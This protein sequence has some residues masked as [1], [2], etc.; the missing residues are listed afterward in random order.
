MGGRSERLGTLSFLKSPFIG[1]KPR[2]NSWQARPGN[3]Q[4]NIAPMLRLY[5]PYIIN[6]Q[7]ARPATVYR[8]AL[9]SPTLSVKKLGWGSSVRAAQA[10]MYMI[11]RVLASLE[12]RDEGLGIRVCRDI[13][14]KQRYSCQRVASSVSCHATCCFGL[15][16]E[17][18]LTHSPTPHRPRRPNHPNLFLLRLK[19][20]LVNKTTHFCSQASG[21][22]KA[23]GLDP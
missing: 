23:S 5:S 7:L 13:A 11:S 22:R 6:A 16:V 12:F 8:Q 19:T 10:R 20:I 3:R 9:P 1:P 21:F 18:H 14:L 4:N 2:K 15:T 17:G